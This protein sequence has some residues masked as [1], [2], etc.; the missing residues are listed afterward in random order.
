MQQT[1]IE[2]EPPGS[3]EHFD[4]AAVEELVEAVRESLGILAV[5]RHPSGPRVTCRVER[6]LRGVEGR[7]SINN[8]IEE[9]R[10]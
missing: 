3:W 6:A 2:I 7:V 9:N 5:S 10:G 4:D 1:L 8:E